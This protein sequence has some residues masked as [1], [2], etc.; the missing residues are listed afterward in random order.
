VVG[1][2]H[3]HHHGD[4]EHEQHARQQRVRPPRRP[5]VLAEQH[6]A[7]ERAHQ[8]QR[9]HGVRRRV[10][11]RLPGHE[12]EGVPEPAHQPRQQRQPP[13][14]AVA[15]VRR[16]R[17]PRHADH[18]AV[19]EPHVEGDA[20]GEAGEGEVE[21]GRVNHQVRHAGGERVPLV[22]GGQ[23]ERRREERVEDA[24]EDDDA[25]AQQRVGAQHLCGRGSESGCEQS[26]GKRH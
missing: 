2:G 10:P 23:V 17:G 25:E 21:E 16:H 14:L 22:V 24:R 6:H 9:L 12:R 8:R 18:G 11:R 3:E 13:A 15:E 20:D 19:E 26:R 7:P 5:P 1:G 4:G